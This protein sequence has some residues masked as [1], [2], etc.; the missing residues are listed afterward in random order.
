MDNLL[1][2]LWIAI[3]IF[4]GWALNM[5][6]CSYKAR[7]ECKD[8]GLIPDIKIMSYNNPY[9][10]IETSYTEYIGHFRSW[11]HA[12]DYIYKNNSN[13]YLNKIF[14]IT[15]NDKD[16]YFQIVSDYT[17]EEVNYIMIY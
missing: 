2:F 1:N 13:K 8:L 9:R 12:Q 6:Y 14:S 10:T 4:I 17:V 11:K 5:T 3:C 16:H 15:L 7:K